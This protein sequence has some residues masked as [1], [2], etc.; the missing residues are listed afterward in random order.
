[1]NGIEDCAI[2][3]LPVELETEVRKWMRTVKRLLYAAGFNAL[4]K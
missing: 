3:G 2:L 1:M 4:V